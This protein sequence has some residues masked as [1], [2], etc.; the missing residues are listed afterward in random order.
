[1]AYD[2]Y[3]Y[4]GIEEQLKQ[5]AQQKGLQYDPS[6]LEG[7]KRNASYTGTQA[8][9]PEQGLQ[10]AFANYD[11]RAKP[12]SGSVQYQTP[13]QAWNAQPAAPQTSGMQGDLYKLLMQRAQQGTAVNR[14][15]PTIRAQ[16][17][18]YA[19]QQDR[20]SRYAI[21]DIAEK[22]GPLAN[23][24]G[25]RR[26]AAERAGQATGAFEAEL[27]GREQADRRG[28]IAQAIE[29]LVSQGRFDQA[30]ALQMQLAEM[31]AALRREGY[32][33]QGRGLDLQAQNQ[34]NQMDQFLREL[35]LREYDT[36]QG[37]DYRWSTLGA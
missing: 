24:T 20:A 1:M 31:D 19:A 37:W 2:D 9:S 29:W 21:D 17:D 6:D 12:S 36:N 14:N 15:D 16:V 7:I 18:P 25:E 3:D 35:A 28:E 23:L 11:Q 8:T 13:T 33:L 27:I 32:Q 26:L 10:N 22:A 34:A 5:R 4:S 30:Q